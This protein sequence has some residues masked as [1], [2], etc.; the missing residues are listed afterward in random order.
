VGA[1]DDQAGARAG[2]DDPFAHEVVV[3]RRRELVPPAQRAVVGDRP[4]VQTRERR[5]PL[6]TSFG[7]FVVERTGAIDVLGVNR[8]VD[9]PSAL[10]IATSA[11]GGWTIDSFDPEGTEGDQ[12]AIV[13][14]PDGVL[15]VAYLAEAPGGNELRCAVRGAAGW[16]IDVVTDRALDGQVALAVDGAGKRHVG[17]IGL[18]GAIYA[19]DA[20]GSWVVEPID[21]GNGGF[22]IGLALD[23]DGRP[24]V[25][26]GVLGWSLDVDLRYAHRTGSGW[27]RE[28]VREGAL[29]N[30]D[31][32]RF[33]L[34]DTGVAHVVYGSTHATDLG[35]APPDGIDQDCDGVDG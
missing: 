13:L 31:A 15:H 21:P 29:H 32:F 16:S 25:A 4:E 17:A 22:G 6:D 28:E 14:A 9:G 12:M 1:R 18:D 11:A 24:H 2:H 30:G 23:R 7:P 8:P 5:V 10:S 20:S 3:G 26:Y 27:V 19:T 35:G 33:G 34:D